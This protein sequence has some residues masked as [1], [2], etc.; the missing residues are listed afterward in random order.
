MTDHQ[1]DV[2]A[3]IAYSRLVSQTFT[4]AEC[5]YLHQWAHQQNPISLELKNKFKH[6]NYKIK[7]IGWQKP[8]LKIK[9]DRNL[10]MMDFQS[11][12]WVK[13]SNN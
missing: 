6:I 1:H 11:G 2:I 10:Y 9:E 13:V 12:N 3:A 7:D 5:I 4:V 8:P